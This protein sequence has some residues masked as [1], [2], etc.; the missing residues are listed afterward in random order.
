MKI[1][2]HRDH[3]SKA[4]QTSG[5][6]RV[7]GNLTETETKSTHRFRPKFDVDLCLYAYIYVLVCQYQPT[8]RV[9]CSV[10]GL[11]TLARLKSLGT[12]KAGCCGTS[13]ISG[14]Y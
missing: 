9:L 7:R 6:G 3:S 13:Y 14:N 5:R 1:E 10:S 8:L 2:R 12:V 11:D 4:L